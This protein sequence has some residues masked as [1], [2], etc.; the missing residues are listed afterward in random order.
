[1]GGHTCQGQSGC[2]FSLER[3]GLGFRVRKC[4]SA[5]TPSNADA[6][7]HV[8]TQMH[9]R[10]GLGF[11]VR[12]C[13]SAFTHSN[14]PK[15]T[16]MQCTHKCSVCVSAFTR[17]NTPLSSRVRALSRNALVSRA[18]CVPAL[19][20]GGEETN[21]R[22]PRCSSRRFT[23]RHLCGKLWFTT[24][25]LCGKPERARPGE[26]C[27]ARASTGVAPPGGHREGGKGGRC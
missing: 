6:C 20:A 15:R 27:C 24:R 5:F 11:R 4:M 9:Q 18:A 3:L 17:A 2:A 22:S 23:T 25:R 1:M 12:K 19:S 14:A 7:L 21:R 16:Q 13:M 10:L 8:P 26:S